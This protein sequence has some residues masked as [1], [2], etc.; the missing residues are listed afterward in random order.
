MKTRFISFLMLAILF[1]QTYTAFAQQAEPTFYTIY[2]YMKV[3]P[4]KW[5]DYL[6]LEKAFKKIHAAKKKAGKL[7]TWGLMEVLSPSGASMEYNYVTYNV[8]AGDAQLANYYEGQYMPDNWSNMLTPDEFELVMN[9]NEIRTLVKTEV[10]SNTDRVVAEDVSSAKI[11]VFNYFDFPATG[12]HD[13]HVKVETDI[14]KPIHAA[15]VK[16]GTMKGWRMLQMQ[17]PFGADMPYQD[18]TVDLYADMTQYLAA[19]FDKYFAKVHPGKDM[20]ALMKQTNEACTLLRGE[21]RMVIDR[22]D[23]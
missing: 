14:W 1:C 12:S 5:D 21:V 20:N 18:A 10:W 6:K 17:M 4:G 3:K 2:D 9:A 16:D 23:W 13:K 11:S 22:L 15:R 19:W 8:Y 7:D